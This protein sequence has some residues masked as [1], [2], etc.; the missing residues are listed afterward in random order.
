MHKRGRL[1]EVQIGMQFF[2]KYY[3]P[4]SEEIK[5]VFRRRH[6]EEVQRINASRRRCNRIFNEL[7]IIWD[8]VYGEQGEDNSQSYLIDF[9][10]EE[11]YRFYETSTTIE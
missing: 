6:K 4:L 8:E 9:E 5:N 11:E 7:E 1:S 2:H 10:G 3:D